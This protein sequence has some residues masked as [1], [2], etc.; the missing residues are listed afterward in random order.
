MVDMVWM[1]LH[2]THLPILSHNV[3]WHFVPQGYQLILC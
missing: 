3:K 2:A 1:R